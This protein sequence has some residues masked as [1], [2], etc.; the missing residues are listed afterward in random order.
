MLIDDFHF[1]LFDF[2]LSL[3]AAIDAVSPMIVDH[4]RR[5]AYIAW[6]ISKELGLTIEQ[7]G[8]LF[9]ASLL[10]DVGSISLKERLDILH[11]DED[12]SFNRHAELGYLL[13]RDFEPLSDEARIIRYHHVQWDNGNGHL[14]NGEAVP[15]ES[16][17]LHLADRISVLI[18][19]DHEVLGQ[20]KGITEKIKDLSGKVFVPEF[21]DAF[22]R[23]SRKE[24]FWLDTSSP[25]LE[26]ELHKIH[27]LPLVIFD[28]ESIQKLTKI[29]SRIIDF[30]SRFTA[31]H[32]S[33]VSATSVALARLAGFSEKECITMEIAGYLHD[34]GKLAV[35]KE[36]L[37]KP[38]KLSME[39]FNIV[40]SHTYHT[41]RILSHMQDFK[42]INQWASFHHE[43]LD[44]SGYPFHISEFDFP[45]GSRIMAVSDVFTAV[46]ED[47]PYREGMSIEKALSTIVSM[48][49]NHA[50]D[51]Y[52]VSLLERNVQFADDAR[53]S[54]QID[55]RKEYENFSK[56]GLLY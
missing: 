23:V 13:L 11:F 37:E 18:D 40:R 4:Q 29:L 16:L 41:Y 15:A 32:S 44:G 54:A 12:V 10:H 46:S 28:I 42:T 27:D 31:T 51:P 36:I 30:R 2:A 53:K 21:V 56:L 43:R 5:V 14:V 50:L 20:V 47:R 35:P 26:L 7:R 49:S 25:N 1:S 33:E 3:S 19:Y 9:F 22:I 48:A 55:A 6:S 17:I 34:L 39:E 8:K 52:V 24:F 38:D 45:L